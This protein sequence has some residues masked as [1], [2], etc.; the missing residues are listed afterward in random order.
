MPTVP[1]ET[2]PDVLA[3]YDAVTADVETFTDTTAALVDGG[4]R[5]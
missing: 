5:Q 4:E 2:F 1:S 3:V